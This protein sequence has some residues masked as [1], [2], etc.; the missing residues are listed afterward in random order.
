[1]Q[2]PSI[3]RVYQTLKETSEFQNF[4][5]MFQHK[6]L[7]KFVYKEKW[8]FAGPVDE[9]RHVIDVTSGEIIG[10]YSLNTSIQ[11]DRMYQPGSLLPFSIKGIWLPLYEGKLFGLHEDTY[12]CPLIREHQRK[13]E[14]LFFIHPLSETLY[15]KLLDSYSDHILTFQALALSSS[16]TVL[17]AFP[18]PTT[19]IY[20]PLMVKLSLDGTIQ[21]IK[22]LVE[23]RECAISVANTAILTQ[24]IDSLDQSF[25]FMYD[26]VAFVPNGYDCGMIYR[27]L[28]DCLNPT[29]A[30]EQGLYLMPLLS[31]YGNKNQSWFKT[32]ILANDGTLTDFLIKRLLEPFIHTFMHLTLYHKTSI[33]AHGQNLL[34]TLDHNDQVQGL[35]YRDMGGVN[36]CFTPDELLALPE[37]M[38]EIVTF[39]NP[40]FEKDAAAALED[41]FVTRGLYPLS[42]QCCKSP[43]LQQHDQE[44]Q[45]WLTKHNRYLK[46]WTLIDSNPHSDS[47]SHQTQLLPTEFYRYGYVETQFL[48]VFLSYIEN[49]HL[50]NT[51]TIQAFYSQCSQI[52]L[53]DGTIVA[54]H[55]TKPF[56][57]TVL[58]SVLQA[59]AKEAQPTLQSVKEPS[60]LTVKGQMPVTLLQPHPTVFFR[61]NHPP[62]NSYK[63]QSPTKK[64]ALKRCGVLLLISGIGAIGIT[65]MLLPYS[66]M[67][68]IVLSLG[69][70]TLI[71]GAACIAMSKSSTRQEQVP[72]S[73]INAF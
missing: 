13:K 32:L 36:H 26:P 28:P 10:G 8:G 73:Y 14:W 71:A 57:N 34:L 29:I 70:L 20:M 5:D 64:N 35:V 61:P 37:N 49:H 46:N 21:G 56:F 18:D 72:T 68:I 30:N 60:T 55:S 19:K 63:N 9:T 27:E 15:A 65:V 2:S 16:R 59:K 42:K 45:E 69:I 31:L 66:T 7:W 54:P 48:Y 43:D 47:E 23:E 50:V 4:R 3:E 53:P 62:K 17:I 51:T 1:M 33:E 40:N 52:K 67:L 6:P 58:K 25:K 38:R 24:K 44:L 12:R 41:H 22:R 11:I 39:Y